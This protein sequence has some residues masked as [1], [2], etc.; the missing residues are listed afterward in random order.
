MMFGLER[1]K[2]KTVSHPEF[3]TITFRKRKGLRNLTIVVR[4]DNEITVSVPHTVSYT[5]AQNFVTEKSN[6]IKKSQKKISAAHPTFFDE[7]TDFSTRSY[8]LKI[9]QHEE[10]YV[11]RIITEDGFLVIYYPQTA[12]INSPKLQK[13]F[14]QCIFDALYFEATQYLPQRTQFLANKHNFK[15]NQLRIKNNLTNLG[16]CS[17]NN[18]INLNLHIMRLSDELIDYVILHELCHT[19]EKNHGEKFWKL[20]DSV[21]NNNAKQLSKQAK[22]INTKMI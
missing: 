5:E 8:K 11:R 1:D 3:G 12:D 21:T 18:N 16:S 15:Y 7:K 4:S 17:Y 2:E 13:I 19:I 10:N 20:L 22:K 6:W 14:Q 9:L